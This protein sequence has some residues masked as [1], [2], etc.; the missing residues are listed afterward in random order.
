MTAPTCLHLAAAQHPR[1]IALHGLFSH[2]GHFCKHD[3]L[4]RIDIFPCCSPHHFSPTTLLL[5]PRLSFASPAYHLRH[6]DPTSTNLHR[7]SQRHRPPSQPSSFVSPNGILC[8]PPFR[9]NSPPSI[10]IPS[11]L[12]SSQTLTL[13][14]HSAMVTFCLVYVNRAEEGKG[15]FVM[16]ITGTA[17]SSD[18]VHEAKSRKIRGVFCCI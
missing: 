18:R 6:T 14:I 15:E 8:H 5:H 4:D 17:E 3:G 10:H 16:N 1:G 9:P 12:S 2:Y 11:S 13:A 7:S